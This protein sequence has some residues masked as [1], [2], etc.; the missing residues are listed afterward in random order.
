MPVREWM[1]PRVKWMRP[2][3]AV[4]YPFLVLGALQGLEPRWVA[5]G[6]GLVVGMR[7]VTAWR[8]P[9]PRDARRLTLP[10]PCDETLRL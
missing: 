10:A 5:V 6:L 3:L 4:A 9:L 7:A 1:R 2:L 8:W